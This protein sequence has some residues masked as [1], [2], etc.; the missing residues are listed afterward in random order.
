MQK[1]KEIRAR[2]AKKCR[3]IAKREKARLDELKA[4]YKK[5][6]NHDFLWH[7]LLQSFATM[8][9][10][11]R[12]AGLLKNE[13]NYNKVTFETLEAIPRKMRE[14]QVRDTCHAAKIRMPNVKA[15]FILGCFD[16]V[17]KLGGPLAARKALLSLPGREA[18]ISFLMSFPGI[19]KKYSRNIMMD[20]YHED[21]RDSIAVDARITKIS[22]AYGLP[23]SS[24][25]EQEEFYL[26]VAK[27]A[28]LEGWEVDRILYNFS[29][30]LVSNG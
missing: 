11:A 27:A 18:K 5:L 4:G 13:E 7:H 23:F 30:E 25:E 8:G 1:H 22:K 16:M 21:F 6:K 26:S 2:L 28:K 20:V 19:G 9:S 17:K 10:S 12:A 14:K 24:Y 3:V 15:N 29:D